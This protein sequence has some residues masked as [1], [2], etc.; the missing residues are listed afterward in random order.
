MRDGVAA[1]CTSCGSTAGAGTTLAA[2]ASTVA[3]SST[4]TAVALVAVALTASAVFGVVS[5]CTSPVVDVITV[6]ERVGDLPLWAGMQ[7]A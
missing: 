2:A 3:F 5:S 7:L 4:S 6:G 1:A